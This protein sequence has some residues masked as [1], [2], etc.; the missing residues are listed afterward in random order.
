MTNDADVDLVSAGLWKVTDDGFQVVGMMTVAANLA[1]ASLPA[2]AHAPDDL[3]DDCF[4]C[5]FR[6]AVRSMHDGGPDV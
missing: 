1:S 6:F 4:S 5:G 2:C 3:H